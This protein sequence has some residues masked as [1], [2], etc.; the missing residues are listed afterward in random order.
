MPPGSQGASVQRG[1]ESLDLLVGCP[2][3]HTSTHESENSPFKPDPLPTES[4]E[5]LDGVVLVG[6]CRGALFAELTQLEVGDVGEIQGFPCL[7]DDWA[8]L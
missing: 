7:R 5:D 4:F 6:V 1:R 2:V 8:V 3:V